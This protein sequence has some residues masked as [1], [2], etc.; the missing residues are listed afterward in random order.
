MDIVRVV[1]VRREVAESDAC[2]DGLAIRIAARERRLVWRDSGC[3]RDIEWLSGT[4]A[5][6]G[7]VEACAAAARGADQRIG[8]A[9]GIGDDS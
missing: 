4:G 1:V 3:G 6:E 5:E 2:V 8:C 9:S 7:S